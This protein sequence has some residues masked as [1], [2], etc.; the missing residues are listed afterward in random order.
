MPRKTPRIFIALGSNVGD[1]AASLRDAVAALATRVTVVR[2]AAAIETAAVDAPPGSGDF[3]NSVAEIATELGPRELLAML[4]EIEHDLGRMRGVR[5]GPRT[6]DLDL[7]MHGDAVIADAPSLVVPHPRMHARRFV[8]APLAEIA[9]DV[10]HPTL[11]R[12]IAELLADLETNG[13]HG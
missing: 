11:R 6:I 2:V 1:R 4:H 9:A 8:L 3:L 7:L 5:N 12:T 10:V 13:C